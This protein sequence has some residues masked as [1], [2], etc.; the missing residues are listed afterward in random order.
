MHPRP[1]GRH[2]NDWQL[3]ANFEL[4]VEIFCEPTYFHVRIPK[5]CLSVCPYPK[6]RNH[7]SFVNISPTLVIDTSMERF[8]RVLQYGNP[9]ILFFSQKGR[10]WILTCILICAENWNHL[11]KMK[12]EW[13]GLHEFS[14]MRTQK[15]E[16]IKKKTCLSESFWCHVFCKQCLA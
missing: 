1:P 11:S 2:I 4:W 3:T 8:S 5:P 14:I 6:K 12:H 10:N 9:K 16:F 15:I 13:K 7:P